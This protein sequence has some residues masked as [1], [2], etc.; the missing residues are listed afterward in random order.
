MVDYHNKTVSPSE[1]YKLKKKTFL[2]NE[3]RF[4]YL[5]TETCIFYHQLRTPGDYDILYILS[6]DDE[7]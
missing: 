6:P 5:G 4:K 7:I 3:N 1:P 2:V